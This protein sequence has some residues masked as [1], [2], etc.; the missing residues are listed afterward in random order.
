MSTLPGALSK[1]STEL[2][3]LTQFHLIVNKVAFTAHQISGRQEILHKD[4]Q[5]NGPVPP[6]QATEKPVKYHS[7]RLWG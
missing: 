5:K 4:K 7:M 1:S 3:L 2:G 6:G